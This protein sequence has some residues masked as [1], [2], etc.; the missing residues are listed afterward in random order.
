MD[1][2]GVVREIVIHPDKVN[3]NGSRDVV[4]IVEVPGYTGPSLLPNHPNW[5]PIR[6]YDS[7][8]V[9]GKR[10]TNCV[11]TQ[12][13]LDL[14]WAITIHKSQGLTIGPGENIKSVIVDFGKQ[15]V[16]HPG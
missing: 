3:E 13:P 10:K 5:V 6:M 2:L 7:D 8:W 4:V 16:G 15:K 12:L 9:A 14:A 11:R 1:L